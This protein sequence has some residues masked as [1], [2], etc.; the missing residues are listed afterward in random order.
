MPL[1]YLGRTTAMIALLS[2][3]SVAAEDLSL[4]G[5]SGVIET[6]SAQML[7]DGALAFTVSNF[8]NTT[9]N[10]L[11]FQILPNVQ[12]AFRY[13]QIDGFSTAQE[14]GKYYDRSFDIHLQLLRETGIWPSLTV[15]LRDFGGTGI[16]SSEFVVAT[17]TV[18]PGLTVTGGLGWGRLAERDGFASPFGDSF[19]VREGLTGGVEQ[20]GQLDFGNWFRGDVAPF[21]GITW[22]ATDKLSFLAEYSPDLYSEESA[23][24]LVEIKSPLNYGAKYAFENGI[25]LGVYYLYGTDVGIQ[26]DYVVDP[27]K[28]VFGSGREAGPA[29]LVPGSSVAAASWNQAGQT[30][31]LRD[32]MTARLADE[33]LTLLALNRTGN[34]AT[35]RVENDRY[36]AP[37]QAFGRALRAMANTLSPDYTTLTVVFEDKGLVLRS[38][39]VDRATLNRAEFAV[40]GAAQI[41][42][43]TQF[44]ETAAP[45]GGGDTG[46]FPRFEADLTYYVAQSF[47]DP[48][49]PIRIEAGLSA[50]AQYELTP[51]LIL[52][53]QLNQ[54][55]FGNVSDVTRES[56]SVIQ[57]VRS[58]SGTYAREA[59]LELTHLTAEYFFRP[60]ADLYGRT[61]VGYLERMFGG[62][63]T[64]V[65]WS[66]QDS[67]LALGLEVNYA[68][69]RDFDIRFGFQDY[70]VV[71]G[72]ASAYYDIGGGFHGQLDVGRYLAGDWGATLTLDREFD[73]GFKVGAFATLTEVSFEDF[74]EGSFDKGIRLEVPVSWFTGQPNKRSL[75]QTLRPVLRDGGARLDVRNR[76]YGL[77]R[78]YR[79]ADTPN[80][81]GRILR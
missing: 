74:G 53:G 36:D 41:L 30:A 19:A 57:R 67:P 32:V 16:Y 39:T 25:N 50:T 21:G 71:T 75:S 61:T 69:Q 6:P 29:P 49:S 3:G 81:W 1:S 18:T 56:N 55:I 77:T 23:V 20:T 68:R 34:R 65:L 5:T 12:G 78:D 40:D 7:P 38:Q 52:S 2:G 26:L 73:N 76:L 35:I 13:G 62:V 70:D 15:G 54:P 51:G 64:E 24:G 44:A 11:T 43:G 45:S 47:F 9:R 72:H 37:P 31:A 60:G 33:G 59:D 10:T 22:Q 66:P 14:D 8:G 80:N 46:L 42:A 79:G 28:P 63:S 58:D 4:Y 48:D 17:K 27:R